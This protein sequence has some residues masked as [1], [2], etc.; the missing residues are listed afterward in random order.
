M[1]Q[2]SQVFEF[3]MNGVP[4]TFQSPTPAAA[5]KFKEIALAHFGDILGEGYIPEMIQGPFK[6]A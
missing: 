5:E 4:F 6:V 3:R 2:V 1:E